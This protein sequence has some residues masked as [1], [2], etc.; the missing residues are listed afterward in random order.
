MYGVSHL[1]ISTDAC[2]YVAEFAICSHTVDRADLLGRRGLSG[3]GCT[4]MCA[5]QSM[6]LIPHI[7]SDDFVGQSMILKL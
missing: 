2:D 6:R 3:G 1:L 7:S 4:G 5:S